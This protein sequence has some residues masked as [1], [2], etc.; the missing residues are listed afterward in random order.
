MRTW[1]L[2]LCL[3]TAPLDP[4]RLMTTVRAASPQGQPSPDLA[5]GRWGVCWPAQT[6]SRLPSSWPPNVPQADVGWTPQLQALWSGLSLNDAVLG[7]VPS[8][9]RA[10]PAAPSSSSA[11]PAPRAREGTVGMESRPQCSVHWCIMTLFM[12]W[13]EN[14]IGKQ[15][16]Y[17]YEDSS[18]N[19]QGL[20]R[21]AHGG[22]HLAQVPAGLRVPSLTVATQ[23][24]LGLESQGPRVVLPLGPGA[25]ACL[26]HSPVKSAQE[27]GPPDRTGPILRKGAV[28]TVEVLVNPGGAHAGAAGVT[29]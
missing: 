11:S 25:P 28:G 29:L 1:D 17:F 20:G 12:G 16:N 2:N 27:L 24:Q 9:P 26:P 14:S 3:A 7:T 19:G 6:P 21:L 8:A 10:S 4:S 15:C 18:P 13:V 23:S 22:P 5:G